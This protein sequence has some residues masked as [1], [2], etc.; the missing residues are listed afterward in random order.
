MKILIIDDDRGLRK[1]LTLILTD[2]GYE[3]RVAEDGEE[4]LASALS[5]NPQMIL[6]DVRMPKK[7]G[8]SFL[9]EYKERGGEALVLVMT[10]YGNIELA[11][12]A[13]QAGAY[14]YIP[15]PFGANEVLLT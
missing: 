10:A 8:L 5:E 6:C 12:Q 15:K 13:M 14:D 3:V 1:S 11:V 9:R 4:G 7:D 2:A